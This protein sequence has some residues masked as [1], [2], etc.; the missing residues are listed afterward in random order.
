[1][2]S[3]V[4]ARSASRKKRLGAY[5]TPPRIVEF[6]AHW[7]ICRPQ[8]RVLE[9][10]C[11][12]AAFLSSL[13]SRLIELDGQVAP[14]QLVG[15]E[16]DSDA[17]RVASQAVPSATV[18][19][20]DFFGEDPPQQ[21]FD[22]VVGNP[23]YVRYHYFFGEA[24]ELGLKRARAA[25][26]SLSRLTSSW[27]PFV[28]HASTFL[29]S[30][31]RLA[32]VLPAEL[33]GTDYAGP[34]R[35]FLLARFR[36]VD[37]ITF[38][39][40]VF[41]GAMVDAILLLAEGQGPG[42]L[43]IHRLPDARAL[44]GFL[45]SGA[46]VVLAGKWVSNLLD[47]QV[48]RTLASVTDIMTPL[49]DL[50]TVDIGIVTGANDFFV[51]SD[52][53]VRAHRLRRPDLKK[54]VART[55]QM[56]GY[57]FTDLDWELE[58]R[59]GAPVWLFSPKNLTSS[60]KRYIEFGE[61]RGFNSTYK[62]G[63]RKEWW[64]LKCPDPPDLFLSYMSNIA[65][66]LIVNTAQ[67]VS[68]NLIHNV[69]LKLGEDCQVDPELLALA[70]MNSAT[71]LSCETMGRAYGGGVLKLETREAERVPVPSL[72][73]SCAARLHEIKSEADGM[74]RRGELD[75]AVE[76]VDSAVFAAL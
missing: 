58:R 12:E 18:T 50:A 66:R 36:S 72:D 54:A 64:R 51:L 44:E 16:L 10:S 76:L 39:S 28:V 63:I 30:G 13:A 74:L 56:P 24:R 19:H 71:L 15:Y 35:E 37:I 33:L 60:V 11:G 6:L 49:G 70:W 3:M 26:V 34:V 65:P 53:D 41:P 73:V 1:M 52:D 67:V 68:T 5:Y 57:A 8:A 40:R 43:R 25:G 48:I 46:G 32:L 21:K 42:T 69:R 14:N 47:E 75:R 31:G 55:H 9:P 59:A 17:A 27:A 20:G 62:C 38:E 22:A 7:A 61:T 4:E 45:P 29:T 2:M 23:P